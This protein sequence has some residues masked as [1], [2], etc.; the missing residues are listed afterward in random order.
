MAAH[1]VTHP[2]EDALRAF[3]PC[4]DPVSGP[5]HLARPQVS[6]TSR[7]PTVPGEEHAD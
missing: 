5:G 7:R 3:A 6:R 1:P 4:C 2:S